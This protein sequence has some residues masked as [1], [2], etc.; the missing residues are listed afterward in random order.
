MFDVLLYLLLPELDIFCFHNYNSF[1]KIIEFRNWKKIEK[2]C[3]FKL[4]FTLSIYQ[5]RTFSGEQRYCVFYLWWDWPFESRKFRRKIPT[6]T[7]IRTIGTMYL[8]AEHYIWNENETCSYSQ[9][10]RCL[11][12]N[13]NFVSW[14]TSFLLSIID[15]CTPVF[16]SI[17]IYETFKYWF[18]MCMHLMT[19][20]IPFFRI[21]N[22]V[23]ANVHHNSILYFWII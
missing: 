17:L 19:Q 20:I 9:L 14:H 23:V 11:M 18:S 12:H 15:T 5:S 16:Q 2:I 4:R 21:T 1:V 22:V 8:R 6:V 13:D 10:H 7:R 3:V